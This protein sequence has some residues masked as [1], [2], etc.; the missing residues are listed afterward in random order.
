MDSRSG[1]H[2]LAQAIRNRWPVPAELR[3]KL[4]EQAATMLDEVEDSRDLMRLGNIIQAAEA[5]NQRDEHLSIGLA[6]KAAGLD[7]CR[8][9]VVYDAP[10]SLPE[11]DP[12]E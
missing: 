9:E 2:R 10:K 1:Q 8:I 6:A 7:N 4:I 5:M 12:A 3:R 11:A